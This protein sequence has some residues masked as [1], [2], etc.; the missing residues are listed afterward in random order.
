MSSIY[1]KYLPQV[2]D[3]EKRIVEWNKVRN[4]LEF[5][6]ALEVRMLSEELA[7]FFEATNLPNMLKEMADIVFVCIGT[8]A[9]DTNKFLKEYMEQTLEM[10]EKFLE[11]GLENCIQN[12][13]LAAYSQVFEVCL[14][15]V[16]EANE[17]KGLEKDAHG[18]VIKGAAYVNPESTIRAMLEEMRVGY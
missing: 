10:L 4:G 8:E 18:K 16:T 1:A 12:N 13:H 11:I 6:P 15:I 2:A 17:A 14:C 3:V 9:K 5:N 7:E